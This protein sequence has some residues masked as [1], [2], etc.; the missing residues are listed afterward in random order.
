M[1]VAAHAADAAEQYR[2]AW[3]R[4]DPAAVRGTFAAAG[5]YLSPITGGRLTGAGIERHA[6]ELLD[7]FPDLVFETRAEGA[8]GDELAV[9]E[10]LVRGTHTGPLNGNP[11][12][13]R[14]IALPGVDVLATAGGLIASARAYFDRRTFAEQLGLRVLVQP[15]ALGPIAFGYCVRMAASFENVP[16]LLS[17]TSIRARSEDDMPRLVSVSQ[18]LMAELGG[19]PG[20]V[21]YLGAVVG[22]SMWTMSTWGVL[23]AATRRDFVAAR[24][25]EIAGYLASG[26]AESALTRLWVPETEV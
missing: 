3:N 5:S 6:R 17:L 21:N 12:T 14:A 9:Q 2:D 22:T 20:F 8:I 13:G 26:L 10:W 15:A 16:T 24:R 19:D 25:R 7:A 4:H 11:P 18:S 23:T 1:I